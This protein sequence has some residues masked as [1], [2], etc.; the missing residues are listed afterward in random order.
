VEVATNSNGLYLFAALEPGKYTVEVI[1]SSIPPPADGD[2]KLT[3]AGSFTI[4]LAEAQSYLD[5]D[6]GIASVL[7]KTGISA[8]QIAYIALSLLL[9]GGAALL[10][11]RRKS[12]EGESDIAA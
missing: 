3:T 6:F 7:P 2:N 1:L 12:D 4:Q 8:D 11:T 5:A 10:V 9:A